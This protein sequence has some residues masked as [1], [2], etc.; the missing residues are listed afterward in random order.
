MADFANENR[1]EY[2]EA[3]TLTG[4]NLNNISAGLVDC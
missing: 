3:N 1:F 2:I 4:F